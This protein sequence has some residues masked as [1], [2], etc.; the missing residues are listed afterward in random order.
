MRRIIGTLNATLLGLAVVAVAVPA[1][2]AP[3][4]AHIS[5]VRTAA[6][7]H[8]VV[9]ATP[10]GSVRTPAAAACFAT[11]AESVAHATSGAVR[12]PANA[13][14]VTQQQLDAGYAKARAA[15]PASGGIGIMAVVIGISYFNTGFSGSSSVHQAATDCD[16]N[17]D[18]DWLINQLTNDNVFSSA[19]AFGQ[20][21]GIYYDLP[22]R[23]A[24]GAR[25]NTNWSGGAMDNRASSVEWV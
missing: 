2:A 14:Q 16:T 4:T 12:L 18:V 17:A 10:A 3:A 1:S 19:Q 5:S 23:P 15:A 11:F 8:C 24:G 13:T 20:C 9:Q 7:P 22:N 25:V 6:T 21:Q